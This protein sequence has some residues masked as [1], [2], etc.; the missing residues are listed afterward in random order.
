MSLLIYQNKKITQARVITKQNKTKNAGKVLKEK[1]MIMGIFEIFPQHNA[2]IV[3][4]KSSRISIADNILYENPS[5]MKSVTCRLIK[6]SGWS[7]DKDNHVA[8]TAG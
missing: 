2:R 8:T 3:I 4:Y 5:H 1:K 6:L 7:Q